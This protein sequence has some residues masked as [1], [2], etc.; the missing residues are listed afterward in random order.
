MHYANIDVKSIEPAHLQPDDQPHTACAEKTYCAICKDELE[1]SSA[2]TKPESVNDVVR[3]PCSHSYHYVCLRESCRHYTTSKASLECALCRS[4]F[5]AFDKPNDDIYV[6]TFH[7]VVAKAK[8]I[9]SGYKP[10]NWDTI[11][12]GTHLFIN[13]KDSQYMKHSAKYVKQTKCQAQVRFADG[14]FCRFA[15]SNLLAFVN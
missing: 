3:L 11:V 8:P 10:V 2:K 9:N 7:T 14:T 15:K 6:K 12:K 13:S 5:P 4:T 1:V